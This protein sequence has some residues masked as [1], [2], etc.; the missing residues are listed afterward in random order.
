M[1]CYITTV[2]YLFIIQEINEKQKQN[3]RKIKSKKLDKKK[4]IRIKY[5]SPSIP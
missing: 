1:M 2:I 3:E 4:K 5:Q